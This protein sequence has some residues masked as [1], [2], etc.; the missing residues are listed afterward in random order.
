MAPYDPIN[1]PHLRDFFERK[2]NMSSAVRS[3][4]FLFI[5]VL[6][7]F[8]KKEY[9]QSIKLKSAKSIYQKLDQF[10]ENKMISS[11]SEKSSRIQLEID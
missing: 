7:L 3:W 4:R 5:F 8:E 10:Q 9:W 1:D 2:F 11:V 6:C